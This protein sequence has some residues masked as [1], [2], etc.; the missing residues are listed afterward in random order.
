M[1]TEAHIL[2]LDCHIDFLQGSS[3]KC[4][5]CE[6][7]TYSAFKHC[8]ACALEQ[9]ICQSCDKPIDSPVPATA[10]SEI[11]AARAAYTVRVAAVNATFDQAV[12][13]FKADLVAYEQTLDATRKTLE[14]DFAALLL[15]FDTAQLASRKAVAEGADAAAE[16]TALAQIEKDNIAKRMA[17]GQALIQTQSDARNKLG[18]ANCEVLDAARRVQHQGTRRARSFFDLEINRIGGHVVIDRSHA[19]LD[20]QY[21]VELAELEED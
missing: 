10:L 2:C 8:P 14:H 19:S 5:T 11:A 17:L 6:H 15:E 16:K 9:N 1:M 12:A 4:A 13:A 7:E 18:A 20:R 21:A 3:H